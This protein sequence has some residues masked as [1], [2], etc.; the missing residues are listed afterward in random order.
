M[1]GAVQMCYK[2]A[3]IWLKL[4]ERVLKMGGTFQ[5]C[6]KMA[7][8]WLKVCESVLKMVRVLGKAW[9]TYFLSPT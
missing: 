9:L 3:I 6:Y 8:I 4:C 7:I 1:G 2:M 5:M